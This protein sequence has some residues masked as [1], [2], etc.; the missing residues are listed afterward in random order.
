MS[1]SPIF[2]GGMQRSGTSLMRSMIGSHPAVAIFQWD[3]P[4]WTKIHPVFE[5]SSHSGEQL[6]D[7]VLDAFFSSDKV[8]KCDMQL[9]RDRVKTRALSV[10]PV[11]FANIAEAF[12]SEYAE[13]VGRPRWGL[14]TPQNEYYAEQ[15]FSA[16]EDARMIQLVRDPRDCSLSVQNYN[17]KWAKNYDALKHAETWQQ[18]VKLG[19][20]YQNQFAGRYLLIKYEDL[21]TDPESVIRRACKTLDLDFRPEMLSMNGHLGWRGNSS[22]FNQHEPKENKIS[23]DSI[24]RYRQ[25]SN[26]FDLRLYQTILQDELKELGYAIDPDRASLPRHIQFAIKAEKMLRGSIL[27]KHASKL[28]QH[29]IRRVRQPISK[30]A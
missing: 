13:L 7:A 12:L 27:E 11:D 21:V 9:D 24:G 2:I 3:L 1:Q 10:K 29:V 14:K 8:K 5:N 28:R 6:C 26:D 23:T 30:A 18:S 22:S 16:H 19:L 17:E 20:R 25:Q 4:V 15:I